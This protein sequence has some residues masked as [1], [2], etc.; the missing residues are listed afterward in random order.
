MACRLGRHSAKGGARALLLAPTRELVLQTHKVVKDL[1]CYLD[2]RTA[3]LLGGDSMEAQF[4]E[5][6]AF[7]DILLAAPGI[8]PSTC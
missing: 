4:A 3:V 5:L 8:H 7:P 1:G 2:L 6:A